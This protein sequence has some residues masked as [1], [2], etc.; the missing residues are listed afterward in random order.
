MGTAGTG[1]FWLRRL[2]SLSGILLSVG[3]IAFFLIPCSAALGGASSFNLVAAIGEKVPLL[4]AI[5]MVFVVAPLM[6]HAAVGLSVIY[7]SQFNVIAFSSYRNW[8]YALQRLTG[9]LVIVPIIHYI[10]TTELVFAFT[11][12]HAEFAYMQKLLAPSWVKAIYGAGVACAAFH[13]GNGISF[14]LTRWGITAS[15]RAQDAA[16]MAMWV[17]TIILAGW[18]ARVILAF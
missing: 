2:H 5:K 17:V 4:S 9:I 18:G 13:I 14:A 11:G 8:M 7:S 1:Y 16:A 10:Y 12:R 3:Y 6:F 15:R